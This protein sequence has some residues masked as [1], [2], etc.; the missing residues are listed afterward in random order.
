MLIA[1]LYSY[2]QFVKFSIEAPLLKITA[3]HWSFFSQ[4]WLFVQAIQFSRP[5]LLY[6]SNKEAI[7]SQQK[8]S[9][10]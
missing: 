10:L 7:D 1:Y 9:C 3:S 4:F 5:N 8:C 6:I 2:V